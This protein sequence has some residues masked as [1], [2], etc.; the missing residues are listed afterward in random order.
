MI[1]D[2]DLS[3]STHI[4]NLSRS[5]FT[6]I[7]DLRRLRPFLNFR[8]ACT[9][10]TAI[11]HSK[12]DYCNSLYLNVHKKQIARLQAIQ[13][14]LARAVTRT[15]KAHHIT[16]VLKSLHWLR[17][18]ERIHFKVLCLT[19]NAIQFSNPMYLRNLF[20]IQTQRSTRSSAS[21]TLVR[22]TPTSLKFSDRSISY[23]APRLW[24]DLPPE[25]RKINNSEPLQSNHFPL[26]ITPQTFRKQIKTIL[27]KK[28][29]GEILT[30]GLHSIARK[31]FYHPP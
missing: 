23:T 15:P 12:M 10:A 11:V 3:F 18:P 4:S 21:L 5:C 24:N 16:P 14:A 28:S 31:S 19:Y 29:Y 2:A 6:Y 22:P 13:N 20:T 1:F 25:I 8:T 30:T 9:I 7:R 27:F 17:V 26:A